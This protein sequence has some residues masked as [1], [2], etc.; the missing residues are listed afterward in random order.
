MRTRIN[1][2]K[3]R[4]S[5]RA[6][7]PSTSPGGEFDGNHNEALVREVPKAR[8]LK[9]RSHIRAGGPSTSPSGPYEGNHNEALVRGGAKP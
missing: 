6:G 3:V 4:S 7:G 9:V 5:I 2:L 1:G 8:G